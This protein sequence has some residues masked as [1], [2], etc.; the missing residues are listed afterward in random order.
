MGCDFID[1]LTRNKT[2]QEFGKYPIPKDGLDVYRF[3]SYHYIFF[4]KEIILHCPLCNNAFPENEMKKIKSLKRKDVWDFKFV[5]RTDA[6]KTE[7]D[8]RKTIK[9]FENMVAEEDN[10][11][12]TLYYK[13]KCDKTNQEIY[14]WF[15]PDEYGLTF[16]KYILK[17][18]S[19]NLCLRDLR[20]KID[21]NIAS[22]DDGSASGKIT[23]DGYYKG[24][25]LCGKVQV[26]DSFPD[27]KVQV[28]TSFPD[29]KVEKVDSFPDE[30][31]KWEFVDSFPDFTIQFVDSFPD[32]T[33]QFVDSFPGVN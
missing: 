33:I 16:K 10:Y 25:K 21:T 7:E 27:F 29:L 32:F 4:Q 13:H 6:G 1:E 3:H 31:G 9:K 20:K 17:D 5:C 15:S 24:K 28:V 2:P 12:K 22:I 26:V 18:S 11:L 23:K 19:I 30:I 8:C 14:L